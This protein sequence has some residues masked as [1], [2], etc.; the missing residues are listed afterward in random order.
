[1]NLQFYVEKLHDSP[2]FKQFMEENPKAY[3]CSGFFTIDNKGKDNQRHIDLYVSS[4]K[5]MFNFKLDSDKDIEISE[6]ETIQDNVPDVLDL[7]KIDFDF[8]RVEMLISEKMKKE[9][10][11]NDIQKILISL[12]KLDGKNF[13][14]CTIFITGFGLIKAHIQVSGKEN[15]L[16]L[17]LFEKR[18]LFD[19]VK[20]VK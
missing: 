19:I 6:V 15:K 11:K 10:I 14:V 1:M 3:A 7:N 16:D 20:R 9:N 17:T 13:L 2:L 4:S 5:K 18:S 12:Q 8:E